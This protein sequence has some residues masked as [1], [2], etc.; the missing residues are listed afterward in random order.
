MIEDFSQPMPNWC[1]NYAIFHHDDPAMLEKLV[2]AYNSGST[3]ETL[4]P[5]PQELRDTVA[6]CPADPDDRDRN[7]QKQK[8]NLER[9]GAKDWYDWCCDKWGAKW[10]FGRE[11]SDSPFSPR[12]AVQEKD[13]KPCVE[14]GFDT[15]WS[16]PLGFYEY[17]HNELGFDV[18]A[19][20]FEGGMGF[21]GS[22]HNG[23][24]NSIQIKE[25]TEEWL[26]DNVPAKM[27]EVFNLIE[28]AAECREAEEEFN[29][30]NKEQAHEPE[31][32]D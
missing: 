27:L 24:E 25:F 5:C 26:E 6:G 21:V 20:Y 19:Y 7:E 29:A 17:L 14:L 8:E 30:Q 12:A 11:Q 22:S 23:S 13:G 18:K 31:S 3:M 32:N 2:A 10:D 4:Y 15:A 1:S 16:P 9:Y 28:Q